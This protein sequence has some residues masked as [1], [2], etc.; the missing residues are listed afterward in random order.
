MKVILRL[1]PILILAV[2]AA[3][4]GGGTTTVYY[5]QPPTQTVPTTIYQT[6]TS[7]TTTTRTTTTTT[8][9]PTTWSWVPSPGN[10]LNGGSYAYFPLNGAYITSGHTLSLSWQADGSLD[11]FIL[12][13]NQYNNFKPLSIASAWEGHQSGS[14]GTI[15]A[16]I[17]NSD[18]YY[19]I[20][21]NTFTFGSSVKLYQAVLTSR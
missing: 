6:T 17:Q 5:Q 13:Q 18:T 20:L 16:Y 21:R 3:S 4:C 9:P 7:Y 19:A 11:C 14:S 1:A 15:T 10:I 2:L 8:A 12:T